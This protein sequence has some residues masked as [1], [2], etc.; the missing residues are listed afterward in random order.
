MALTGFTIKRYKDT[1]VV[2]NQSESSINGVLEIQDEGCTSYS[3]VKEGIVIPPGETQTVKPAYDGL[4]KLNLQ[5]ITGDAHL[6][7]PHYTDLITNII[8]NIHYI[9][10]DC[11]PNSNCTDCTYD[12]CSQQLSTML[13][14][15][16]YQQLTHP[17][18]AVFLEAVF[19][20]LKC[21]V[22]ELTV[23]IVAE[24]QMTGK[25][26]YIALLNKIL[27]LYYLAFYHSEIKQATTEETDY[28]NTKFSFAEI[29]TCIDAELLADVQNKID[30]M[31][32]FTIV[33]GAYQNLPP[34]SGNNTIER[35]NRVTTVLEMSMFP[36]T[37]PEGDP[38][39]AMKIV[40]INANNKGV[41]LFDNVPVVAEQVIT[42]EA[43]NAGRLVHVG[44]DVDD[45]VNDS[46]TYLL[47][48]TVSQQWG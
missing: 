12:D 29:S 10:C 31:G 25:S 33:S 11:A 43:I 16:S 34:I 27:S 38:I 44:A 19:E 28:I 41:Y 47:R 42:V 30:N 14:I 32:T 18:H 7:I 20:T 21:S 5:G 37:E 15:V 2:H 6:Y 8:S 13:K 9:L 4:Y 39:D 46:F 23:K 48:D 26:E 3:V 17:Q 1:Y 35:A 40:A 45:A 36:Y 22:K 24:E